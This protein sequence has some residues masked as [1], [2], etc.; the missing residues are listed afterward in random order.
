MIQNIVV[1]PQIKA[2]QPYEI[3]LKSFEESNQLH[4]QGSTKL[5][6]AKP[7]VLKK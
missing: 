6:S 3:Q 7:P 2:I 5:I 1:K 4:L